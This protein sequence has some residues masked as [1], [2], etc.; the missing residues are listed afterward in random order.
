MIKL[1]KENLVKS[2]I[3]IV[4][5]IVT[6]V[7]V[8]VGVVKITGNKKNVNSS[9]DETTTYLDT[10]GETT[11]SNTDEGETTQ[12]SEETTTSEGKD[13]NSGDV[14]GTE[15]DSS[16][17]ETTS[18]KQD[19]ASQGNEEETTSKGNN[20][21][22]SETIS[23]EEA[24]EQFKE[25]GGTYVDNSD[26]TVSITGG[27]VEGELIIPATIDGKPVVLSEN[28]FAIMGYGNDTITSVE[29]NAEVIGACA[30][31]NCTA[32]KTVII[33]ENVKEIGNGAFANCP[34]LETVVF[35]G[36][37]VTELPE[38]VFMG[39]PK[40]TSITLPASITKVHVGFITSY[41]PYVL[42][43][44]P[45]G[46]VE[47]LDYESIVPEFTLY[48]YSEPGEVTVWSNLYGAEYTEYD[49]LESIGTETRKANFKVEYL[50]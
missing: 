31:Q 48:T 46:P 14:E 2:I 43:K 7:F 13:E 4:A 37:G 11:S 22:T 5:A 42:E 50:K 35:K 12:L 24:E 39:C 41:Q 3:I 18:A 38:Y 49:G 20:S 25:S 47:D 40:M 26:G 23:N 21:D 17:E 15:S 29:I 16:N 8:I 36:E 30:F 44:Y 19:D 32:L 34:A 10:Q 1:I 9:G 28:A 27:D 45:N 6:I 33:G